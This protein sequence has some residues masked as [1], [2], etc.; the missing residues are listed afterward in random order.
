MAEVIDL[1]RRRTKD[2]RIAEGRA[3]R[4][5]QAVASALSC[6]ACPRRCAHCGLPVEQMMPPPV[7]APFPFCEVCQDEYE[8]YRRRERGSAEKEAFWHNDEW[9]ETW[10]AWLAHMKAGAKFRK[11]PAFLKLMEEH[12]D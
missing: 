6:G 11:T 10:R 8:A 1:K 4:R 12:L 9:A 7:D 5:A 2:K 3:R